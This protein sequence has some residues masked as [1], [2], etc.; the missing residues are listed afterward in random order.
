[1]TGTKPENLLRLDGRQALVTGA[2]GNIGRGIAKLMAAKGAKVIVNDLGTSDSG[3]GEDAGPAQEV[4]DEIKADGGDGAANM[5]SVS[6]F[7]GAT[8]MVAQAL[9]E[10]GRLDIIVNVAGILRDKMLHK[11]DPD[12]W[13]AVTPLVDAFFGSLTIT[14][15]AHRTILSPG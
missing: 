10:F 7:E 6:T 3:K 13:K 12:D 8:N 5:D 14:S 4:V 11:M 15:V 2:S 1:M 9:K